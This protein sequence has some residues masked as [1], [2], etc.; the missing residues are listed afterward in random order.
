MVAAPQNLMLEIGRRITSTREALGWTSAHLARLAHIHRTELFHLERGA[1]PNVT[2]VVMW[3]LVEAL[4]RGR[5]EPVGL[6]YEEVWTGRRPSAATGPLL[7]LELERR[8]RATEEQVLGLL[9]GSSPRS[10]AS[11]LRPAGGAR[12]GRKPARSSPPSS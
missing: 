12:G 4:A 3:R 8:L 1:K 9:E 11:T 10:G 5:H 2:A 7:A 6:L